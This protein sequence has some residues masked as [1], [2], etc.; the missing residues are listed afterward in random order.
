MAIYHLSA[1]VVSRAKGQSTI[2]AAAYRAGEK[3]RD[4]ATG[5]VKEYRARR[6]RIIFT[7]IFAPAAA[8]D[9]MRDRNSLWNIVEQIEHRKN[10]TLAREI[11][12]ALPH[13]LTQEQNIW[14]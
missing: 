4:E 11:E 8:P 5:D 9:W 3:L 7:G 2:A 10:S 13:E 14:L 6:D 12:I 1:K